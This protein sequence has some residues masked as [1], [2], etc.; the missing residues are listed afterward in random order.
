MQQSDQYGQAPPAAVYQQDPHYAPQQQYYPPPQPP[1]KQQ[2]GYGGDVVGK[3]V[4]SPS[5]GGGQEH[6]V[7]DKTGVML[8]K[9]RPS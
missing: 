2:Q 8:R 6:G 9:D 3:E 4:F 1:Q 5:M 7:L